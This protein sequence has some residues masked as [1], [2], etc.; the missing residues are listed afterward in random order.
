MYNRRIEAISDTYWG[1]IRIKNDEEDMAEKLETMADTR[2]FLI[3]G[4]GDT[5]HNT[6]TSLRLLANDM[7]TK[8]GFGAAVKAQ[9]RAT[10]MR[11]ASD[12][13][14]QSIDLDYPI[15]DT[16]LFSPADAET[17]DDGVVAYARSLFQ[18][19]TLTA[20]RNLTGRS[21]GLLIRMSRAVDLASTFG[22][23]NNLSNALPRL[24]CENAQAFSRGDEILSDS[25]LPAQ[26]AATW[27]DSRF[28]VSHIG[29]LCL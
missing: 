7:R 4:F 23:A 22:P 2:D 11:M 16:P 24:R 5:G 3:V 1:L 29:G 12:Y 17:R 15:L 8:P 21:A 14:R 20:P 9:N 6:G 28:R 18:G 26:K 10:L 19:V 13:A 25:G 27:G